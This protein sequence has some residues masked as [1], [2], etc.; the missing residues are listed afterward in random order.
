MCVC[1]GGGGG[2]MVV[3]VRLIN[4]TDNFGLE[5]TVRKSHTYILDQEKPPGCIIT[6]APFC[7]LNPM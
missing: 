2:E 5:K 6:D 7:H 4:G 3:L 1:V